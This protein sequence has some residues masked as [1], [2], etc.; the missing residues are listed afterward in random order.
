[1]LE[2]IWGLNCNLMTDSRHL[3]QAIVIHEKLL[4]IEFVIEVGDQGVLMCGLVS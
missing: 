3:N 4:S 1:M 2:T